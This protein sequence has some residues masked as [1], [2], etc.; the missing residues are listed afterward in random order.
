MSA[1]TP[2]A[3]TPDASTPVPASAE[4][5]SATLAAD[6]LVLEYLRARGHKSAEQ[7]LTEIIGSSD[8]K[9]KGT[10]VTISGEEL[11]KK[12]TVFAEKPALPGENTLK[13]TLGVQKEL[14]SAVNSSNLQNLI[15]SIGPVGAE[16]ILSLDP[17]DKQEGFRELE[18]WVEGSLDMYR[19]EF[20]PIIFP[21]FCHFYLDLVQFGFKDAAQEFFETF[22]PPLEALHSTII[23]RLSTLRL[24]S[25]IQSDETAQR[26][27]NEKYTIRMSR[28]GFA[29]LLGWLTE[30]IGGEAPGAGEGFS[31]EKGRRGRAAVM[32]VV[33]NHLKF[34]VA[35]S[36]TSKASGSWE[37]S[38]GLLSSLI[39][40]PNGTT[41]PYTNPQAF[42]E[43]AGELKLGPAPISEELR[44]EAEKSLREQAMMD[45]DPSA[46]YDNQH[47]RPTPAT[48]IVSPATSDLLPHPPTFRTVDVRREVEKVRDARKRIRL[49]P[50]ALSSADANGQGAT[51]RQRSLPS[52]CAY[53]LH[54]VH[55]GS[56]CC[57][58]SQD[59]SL[60]AAGFE[61][62]YIRLWNLKGEPLNGLQSDFQVTNI[63]DSSSLNNI[64]EKGGSP[65]RK[66]I[67][68]S[69]PVY[70]LAFDP[71]G[72]SATQPR[73]LLSGSADA[74][75]RLW[76]LDTM[77]NVVAYRGHQNPIWD[78]DWSPMGIYF[79]TASRDRTAR[80]WS[81]DR[82]ST[83]R[84]Y[85]GHSSDVDC[86][87][88]HPNSLYVATGS[89]D[90]TARLW[91]VQ[92][93]TSV[94]VFIGHQ[95]IVSTLAFSPDGRY[96]ATAG[97]DLAI[98]LWD[99]GSGRRVKKMTGHTAS[100]YSLAFSA[101]SSV[102]VSGGADWTVRCWDIKGA[103][104]VPETAR[105]NGA[106]GGA[107]TH[108]SK[109]LHPDMIE[110][111]DLLATFPTKRTPIINVHFTPRNL[112]L[113]AGPYLSTVP[114]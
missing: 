98:N 114:R 33:N 87:R 62:S 32:R 49:D 9:G 5:G 66:L 81:T 30:G 86:V 69:G 13:T 102:L 53:T 18:S 3:S 4:Q 91:D 14:A 12:L 44:T 75:A 35:T 50:T 22:S 94:R 64:R 67:G 76:S 58:F 19:P 16:E 38:T 39:P 110:T 73:Y 63:R 113:V 92:R 79:A 71:V 104:G 43:A 54:D 31:G 83:L 103:G 96:L 1:A 95:G 77:T 15:A 6:R 85:A 68:H 21:I 28:S 8:E 57:T 112:C 48:G 34:D 42:N 47:L 105:T 70:S 52:I 26:F 88:F 27:R 45:R 55:E 41:T 29:L 108:H 106:T 60:M 24:P 65:T 51:A 99:L 36:Q 72:G 90:W 17:N 59:T 93:G 100:V 46:Q 78:V 89:S 101:E 40:Q 61:E 111:T 11:V 109:D 10:Q 7:A 37:D 97:E 2:T 25:H 74:T 23:H 107:G 84:I 20:R 80:L 82:T 56:P